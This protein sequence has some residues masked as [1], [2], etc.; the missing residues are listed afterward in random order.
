MGMKTT[1]ALRERA[2]QLCDMVASDR[3]ND[4]KWSKSF[5]LSDVDEEDPD[6]EAAQL[7]VQVFMTV[8]STCSE[9]G[10]FG[11]DW[12]EAAAWLRNNDLD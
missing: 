3:M 7:A 11:F 9:H 4:Q 1:K 12:A 6:W 5:D 10:H 8:P 2:A